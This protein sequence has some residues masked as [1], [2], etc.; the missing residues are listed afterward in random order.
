[1]SQGRKGP[2][3]GGLSALAARQPQSVN[4]ARAGGQHAGLGRARL[5]REAKPPTPGGK[6]ADAGEAEMNAWGWVPVGLTVW[7][8]A[9]A[10][11][12]LWLGPLLRHC[13]QTLEATDRLM[14]ASL[15]EPPRR[16]QRAS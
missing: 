7:F 4:W 13:S 8:A 14:L 15:K 2:S 11:L 6:A 5:R 1:M 3:A 16:W 12:G 10:A 9:A